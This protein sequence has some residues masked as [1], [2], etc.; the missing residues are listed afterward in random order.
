[1]PFT[2]VF[3]EIKIR[4]GQ[5]VQKDE[6]VARYELEKSSAIQL[7]RDMLFNEL[8]DIRR[9]LEIERQ[10]IRR[11]ERKESELQQLTT[12]NLSPQLMLEATQTELRLT[13]AYVSVLEKRSAFAKNFSNKTLIEIRSALGDETIEP[14]Q[15]PGYVKLKA[16]ISG[17][18]LSLFPGLR[19]NALLP[20]GTLIAT[21]GTMETMLIRSLVYEKDILQLQV[22]E[23]V[24]FFPDSIPEKSFPATISSIHWTPAS[25]DPNQPSYYQ[26]EMTVSNT[27]LLLRDGFKGRIEYTP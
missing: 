9:Y 11:L 26:V 14:G 24:R 7:G 16:P 21:I 22:G 12:E 20:E 4:P 15:I 17:M 25:H 2:G 6:Y 27:D 3:T 13:R 23:Q 1:M 10:K 18:V 8:D 19:I 5:M